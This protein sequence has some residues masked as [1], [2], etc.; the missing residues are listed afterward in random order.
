[1]TNVIAKEAVPGLDYLQSAFRA[2]AYDSR[3]SDTTYDF[4]YPVS[5]TRNT[6]CLRWVIPRSSGN[7]VPNVEKMV[8]ALDLKCVNKAKDGAPPIGITSAPTN[9]F[10]NSIFGSLTISYNTTVV[11]KIDNYP[12]FSYTSLLMNCND[13]DFKTWVQNRCF[14][15]EGEDEDLD[16]TETEG[17]N[18]RRL[19]FGSKITA[20]LK[21]KQ[22]DESNVEKDVDNPDLG[23][24][25]Y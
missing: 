20:P 16:D 3:I 5:A 8:L 25:Q 4:H 13:Q 17:W 14:F 11:C 24:F 18:K 6:T 19:C 7:K 1:M 2:P 10:I 21:I 9:N 12:I 23:K 15:K 22:K